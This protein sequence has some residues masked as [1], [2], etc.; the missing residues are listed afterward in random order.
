MQSMSN[1][2]IL[3]FKVR[4]GIHYS[5]QLIQKNFGYVVGQKVPDPLTTA[6]LPC[7]NQLYV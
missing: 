1:L 3:K 2:A 6:L 4:Y 7:I 5:V